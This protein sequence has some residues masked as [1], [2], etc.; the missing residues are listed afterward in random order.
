MYKRVT[1][2]LECMGWNCCLFSILIVSKWSNE[3]GI[4][5]KFS[6]SK[7]LIHTPNH[8][9]RRFRSHGYQIDKWKITW[10]K[11]NVIVLYF[12]I[13]LPPLAFNFF[14]PFFGR[15]VNFKEA[16]QNIIVSFKNG[17]CHFVKKKWQFY[18]INA[19]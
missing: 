16:K 2:T 14:F 11:L 7:N 6:I 9:S 17:Q 3:T 10:E 15:M 8:N 5:T 13:R 4:N 12:S 19:K 18:P 1:E